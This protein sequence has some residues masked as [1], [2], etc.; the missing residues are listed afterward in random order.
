MSSLA[1]GLPQVGRRFATES[2][3]DD[4]VALF[5][6]NIFER[7]RGLSIYRFCMVNTKPKAAESNGTASTLL[8]YKVSSE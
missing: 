5:Y 2:T 1:T 4:S 8:T 6:A 7:T 3:V